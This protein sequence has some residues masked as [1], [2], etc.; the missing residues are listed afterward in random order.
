MSSPSNAEP[1]AIFEPSTAAHTAPLAPTRPF[2][3]SVR[4]E[5]WEYRSVWIAPLVSAGFVLFGFIIALIRLPAKMHVTRMPPAEVPVGM[6]S[7]AQGFAA[8]VILATSLTVC[9][10]YCLGALN[11]ERRDRSILFWKSLPVSDITTVL[12]K[13]FVPMVALPAVA[14]AVALAT[15]LVQLVLGSAFLATHGM[16]P[17]I[18]W[19]GLLGHIVVGG[20]YTVIV[21]ALWY[22]PIYGW[23]L[24]VSGWA[25]RVPLLWAV[26]PLLAVCIVEKIGFDTDYFWSMLFYRITGFAQEAFGGVHIHGGN[27]VD[28]LMLLTPDRF[29]ASLG[30]WIG[31][32]F[33]AAF[34]ATAIWLRRYR[35]PG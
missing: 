35:D 22:A 15:Q 4:R 13:M 7:A 33:A 14:F 24:L 26:L 11:H 10:I 2:Y 34:L 20:F 12:S 3:W 19:N 5:L 29:V 27:I 23:L 25:R 32:A 17:A 31:L 21:T 28:P 9:V 8:A 30:L 1:A 16:N 6:L 18:L